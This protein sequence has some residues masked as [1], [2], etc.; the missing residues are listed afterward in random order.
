M[1]WRRLW[2][3]GRDAPPL[4]QAGGVGDRVQ[5]PTLRL[6]RVGPVLNLLLPGPRM[7]GPI[8]ISAAALKCGAVFIGGGWD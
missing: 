1:G 8:P 6:R 2:W 7:T 5:V 3:R 4:A